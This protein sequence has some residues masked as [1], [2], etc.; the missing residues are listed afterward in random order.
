MTVLSVAGVPGPTLSV[1]IPLRALI[2]VGVA[3]TTV[4]LAFHQKILSVA[5]EIESFLSQDPSSKKNYQ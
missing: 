1:R 4:I 3:S 5:V 2:E